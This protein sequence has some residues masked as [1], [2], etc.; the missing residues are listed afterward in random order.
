MMKK[1]IFS[2]LFYIL[3]IMS[4]ALNFNVFPIRIDVDSDK[5]STHEVVLVN[6]TL[7]PLRIEIYPE[8]DIDFGEKYNLNDRI[9]LFPKMVSIKPGDSQ[10]VRLRVKPNIEMKNGEYKSYLTFKEKPSEIKSMTKELVGDN[11]TT[12]VQLITELSIPIYSLGKNQI[13]DGKL[14]NIECVANGSTISLKGKSFSNGNTSLNFNYTLDVVGTT[15]EFNGKFANS[16]RVGEKDLS[17]VIQTKDNLKGK[18]AKLK[19]TDQTGK[20]HFN[21]EITIK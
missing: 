5:V 20:V 14:T 7:E 8:A 6:N 11:V 17:L 3:S 10:I 15:E 19:I 16:A 4:F 2:L 12:G 13:I 18:R 1:V 21:D 9:T